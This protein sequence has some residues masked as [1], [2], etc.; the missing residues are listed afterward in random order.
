MYDERER[1]RQAAKDDAHGAQS[2]TKKTQSITKKLNLGEK[3]VNETMFVGVKALYVHRQSPIHSIYK[4]M[5]IYTRNYYDPLS[6]TNVTS[7]LSD[8]RPF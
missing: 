1:E 5:I 8:L 3:R 2:I 4:S 7:P 6:F